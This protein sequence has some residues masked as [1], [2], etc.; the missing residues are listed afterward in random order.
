MFLLKTKGIQ[1]TGNGK[2]VMYAAF[3]F[4]KHEKLSTYLRFERFFFGCLPANPFV[5]VLGRHTRL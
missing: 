4:Y 5:F 1:D 3:F 2:H